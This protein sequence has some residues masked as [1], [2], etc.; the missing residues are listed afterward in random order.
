MR[1]AVRVAAVVGLGAIASCAPPEADETAVGAEGATPATTGSAEAAR[2]WDAVIDVVVSR[3]ALSPGE[4][5]FAAGRP[6]LFAELP[7]TLARAV[8]SA[9]GVYVGTL[10]VTGPYGALGT[11]AFTSAAAG[12]DRVGLRELLRDVPV[13]VMLPGAAGSDPAYAAMVDLLREGLG[14]HRAVHFHWGGAYPIE[15]LSIPVPAEAL[16]YP[17]VDSAADAMYRRAITA[18]DYQALEA[19]QTAFERAARAGEVR[20]T[21][22]SGTD[23]RFRIGDRPVN[24][25]DGDASAARAERSRI[26][27]DREIEFPAGVLRVAPLENTVE[28]VIA[29]PRSEWNG[30]GA[31]EDLVLTIEAG[32]I[33]GV[34][35]GAGV[36]HARAEL[37][38]AGESAAFR[39]LGVGFNPLLAVPRDDPWLPYFGYGS[40]VVRLSLGDNSELGGDV[41]GGWVKWVFVLDA[42]VAVD[43]VRWVEDGRAVR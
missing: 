23:L 6:D 5:V 18:V 33:T 39:E 29:F 31:V 30:G 13:G 20:I 15:D 41:G 22:P 26:L 38:S 8:E 34:E 37:E 7:A 28:G 10:G 19:A 43:G 2:D 11:G 35:A 14:V 25:Q 42:T 27:I 21:T 24:R 1:T 3:L 36:E 12:L 4:R 16:A 40:G 32:R 9:G 17:T